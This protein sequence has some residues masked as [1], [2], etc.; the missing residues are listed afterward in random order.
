MQVIRL[1]SVALVA[2]GVSLA[3]AAPAGADVLVNYV[4]ARS[5]FRA[6]GS[7]EVGVWFKPVGDLRRS[8]RIQVYDA[9]R[10]LVFT[11]AGLAPAAGWRYWRVA[12]PRTGRY[13]VYYRLPGSTQKF[14]TN[15]VRC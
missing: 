5:C 7:F 9:R 11:R 14:V 13:T 12:V 15:V 6:S 2:A 4:P 1:L 3:L 8:F 10:R